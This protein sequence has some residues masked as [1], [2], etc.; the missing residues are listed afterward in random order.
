MWMA[1]VHFAKREFESIFVHRFSKGTMPLMN[2]FKN[3][4]HYHVFGGF[5]LAYDVYG[6][7]LALGMHAS[8]R[9]EWL[10]YTCMI[11]WTACCLFLVNLLILDLVC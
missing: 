1:V 11:L 3:S 6:Q 5:L 9:P 2:I 7:H 8:H 4:F 10:V